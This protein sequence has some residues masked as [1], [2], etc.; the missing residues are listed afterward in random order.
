MSNALL[1]APGIPQV[2]GGPRFFVRAGYAV[3][4][5]GMVFT[6][7]FA[8][9]ANISSAV[10][11]SGVVAVESS[12]KVVQHLEGGLVHEILVR[13]ADAVKAGQVLIRLNPIKAKATADLY[14]AQL[15]AM[16]GA[17]GRLEAEQV[18]AP[19][20]SFPPFLAASVNNPQ[21]ARIMADEEKVFEQGRQSLNNQI[22]ILNNRI[23]QL[24]Q[25]VIGWQQ[26]I[27]ALN[28]QIDSLTEQTAGL[29]GLN[30][31]GLYATNDLRNAE[32][33]LSAL[34]GSLGEATAN[35]ATAKGNIEESR[36]Q[37][38]QLKQDYRRGA[39]DALATLRPQV[40]DLRERLTVADDALARL[41]IKAPQD[42]VVQNLAVH[43]IGG[44][45]GAGDAVMEIVPIGD[46]L[47]VNAQVPTTAVDSIHADM[48]AEVKFPAFHSRSIPILL[49]TVASVSADA[50][51]DQQTGN[52]YYLAKVHVDP[53]S[54]P[55]EFRGKLQPGMP[56]EVVMTTG[57]RTVMDYFTRPLSEAMFRGMREE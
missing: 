2:R 15:F 27:N 49:G 18:E 16:L 25:Q 13:D 43:T 38:D 7:T 57:E 47:I 29:S 22:A 4:L 35:L 42:G 37:I 45:I 48:V 52:M 50:I 21:A 3:I 28:Q 17:Q 24:D 1:K 44:V 53:D 32:R 5:V 23:V 34:S 41:E 8:A 54:I 40:T 20:V 39:A 12:R 36:L 19:V 56:A 26:Q 46:D 30:E 55:T 33:Q 6:G 11:A 10:F 31:S 9:Y 14:R 51:T